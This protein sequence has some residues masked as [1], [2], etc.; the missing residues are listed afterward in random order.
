MT[1]PALSIILVSWNT[2]DLTLAC[3]RSLQAFPPGMPFE[4][5]V[6]DNRSADGTDAAVRTGHPMARLVQAGANLGF[7]GGANLGASHARGEYLLFL[8]TD[9]EVQSGALDALLA[10]ADE[11]PAA[12]LWGGRTIYPDGAVNPS[13]CAALPGLWSHICFALGFNALFSRSRLFNPEQYGDWPRDTPGE[14]GMIAGCFLL[15]RAELFKRLGGFDRD[16]FMYGE[17]ADLCVR[18]RA[19]G[20]RPTFTPSATIVHRTGQS[21]NPGDMRS[22]LFGAKIELARRHQRGLG[23]RLSRHL[24]VTGVWLRYAAYTAAARIGADRSGQSEVWRSVWRR[25]HLWRNGAVAG[26]LEPYR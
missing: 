22:Y 26:A 15:V 2:R 11:R 19:L 6:V 14:V 18:A 16:F 21:S 3:L 1:D 7:G 13:N 20:A 17:D 8:N 5:I 23:S 12:G 24:V 25:R 4:V 10:F 9:A